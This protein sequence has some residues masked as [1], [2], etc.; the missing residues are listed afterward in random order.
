MRKD[1]YILQY[2]ADGLGCPH[3]LALEMTPPQW[4]WSAYEPNP[5][6]V[7][8]NNTYSAKITD[9][10]IDRIDFDMYGTNTKYVSTAFLDVCKEHDVTFRAIPLDL[11]L[12]DG[13]K[14]EKDYSIFLPGDIVALL[15]ADKSIAEVERVVETGETMMSVLVP[16]TP[17]YSKITKFV[18]KDIALPHLFLC[19]EVFSLVCTADFLHTASGRGLRGLKFTPLDDSYIYDP[20]A[21]W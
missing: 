19:A 12:P 11:R 8:I 18:A 9:G 3:H 16:N 17:V 20:W 4:E 5:M 1:L 6:S 14:P 13:S 10:E 15:D 21:D 7:P 2:E